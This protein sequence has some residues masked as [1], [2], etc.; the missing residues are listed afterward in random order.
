MNQKGFTLLEVLLAMAVGGVILIVVVSSIFQIVQGRVGIVQKS[1]AMSDIDNAAHWL[2]RDMVLAQTT[3][4]IDKAP[5]VSEITINWDDR[6]GWAADEGSVQHSVVYHFSGSQLLRNYDGEES[7][8]GRYVTDVGFS[9]DGRMF[10]VTL[11][12]C[13]GLPGSTMT[14]SFLIQ[15]RSDL[16]P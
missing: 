9:I 2:T 1:A 5:P 4:L 12:S 6:T 10:T 13:P 14:R 15:I 3:S 11:T 16:G 8:A 7:I